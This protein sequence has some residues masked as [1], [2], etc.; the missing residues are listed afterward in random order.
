MSI[1]PVHPENCGIVSLIIKNHRLFY[2]PFLL[3]VA[4]AVVGVRHHVFFWDTIQLGSKHA[5]WFYENNFQHLL[6]PEEIDSGHPPIFGLYLAALWKLVSKSLIVSHFAMLPFLLVNVWLL[7]E[8]GYYFAGRLGAIGLLLLSMV[9]PV[10]A[11]QSLLISPDVVLVTFFLLALWSILLKKKWLLVLAVIGLAAISMRGMMV[12]VALFGF[13]LLR[14]FP[15][16]APF[17]KTLLPFLP[18]GLFG[19]A[20]LLWH[21]QQTGWIGYHPGSP[22]AV[23]FERVDGAGFIKNI[24]LLGW[25]MLDFGRVFVWAVVGVSL[26]FGYKN[27]PAKKSNLQ[28]LLI[29]L[30]F[31]FFLLTINQLPYKGLL[32]LRYFLPLFLVVNLLAV[33]LIFGAPTRPPSFSES[34]RSYPIFLIAFLGLLLGNLW[35]YPKHISQNWDSTLAHLPYYELRSDMHQFIQ[36][37]QIPLA[38]IGT[39]FPEIGPLKYRDLSESEDGFAAADLEKQDYIFYAS[40]MNDFSDEELEQLETWQEVKRLE[41]GR[42]CVILYKRPQ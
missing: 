26:F 29:L 15:K 17:W 28:E 8:L 37:Q 9:D 16:L 32:G 41:R 12:G 24:A 11:S 35:I 31:T 40:V 23:S 30:G 33:Y 27:R 42:L 20:F 3:L 38:E 4:F 2:V 10:L 1:L 14:H 5:H 39:V 25:R 22:W 7:G 36:E 13:A 18:G 19:L 21:Y 34:R 6:L